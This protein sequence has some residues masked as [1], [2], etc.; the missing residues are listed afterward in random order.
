M[1][2]ICGD[3]TTS[4]KILRISDGNGKLIDSGSKV[5]VTGDLIILLDVSDIP[6]TATS[7]LR[8]P[9]ELPFPIRL[10][11]VYVSRYHTYN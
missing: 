6:A 8:A 7:S 1:C 3:D 11:F 5:C 10:E 4:V 9:R 2:G